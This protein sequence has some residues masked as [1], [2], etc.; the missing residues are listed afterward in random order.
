MHCVCV[1]S[2]AFSQEESFNLSVPQH[3]GPV[4]LSLCVQVLSFRWQ[5]PSKVFSFSWTEWCPEMGPA[6]LVAHQWTVAEAGSGESDPSY[7][8]DD[9]NGPVSLA[10]WD[11]EGTHTCTVQGTYVC[12]THI[13]TWRVDTSLCSI[14][15]PHT[16]TRYTD[17]PV[18]QLNCINPK[19]CMC[20]PLVH[21]PLHTHAGKQWVWYQ[22]YMLSIHLC[23]AF[24]R[25]CGSSVRP[26]S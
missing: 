7:L 4:S 16:Y 20:L 6:Q 13:Q 21:P 2:C 26:G 9:E 15:H 19:V 10:L 24:F 3:P 18:L 8:L 11:S 12:I 14:A 23:R 17:I 5:Q 1:Y 25:G 22:S